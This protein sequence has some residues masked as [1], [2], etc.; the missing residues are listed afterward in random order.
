MPSM[1]D[2]VPARDAEGQTSFYDVWGLDTVRPSV[3]GSM[4][5]RDFRFGP[6]HPRSSAL[7][8]QDSPSPQRT[9]P[10]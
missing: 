2:D 3:R 8:I 4:R 7:L 9:N 5:A 6:V 1:N 10:R